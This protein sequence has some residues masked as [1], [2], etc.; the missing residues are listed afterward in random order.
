MRIGDLIQCTGPK[1]VRTR[2]C[3]VV[4]GVVL[5]DNVVGGTLK[6]F[7]QAKQKKL[8]VVRSQCKVISKN[9]SLKKR[10]ANSAC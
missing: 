10:K 2:D 8:W 6:V 3:P 5:Y 4:I 9:D 1:S 7:D